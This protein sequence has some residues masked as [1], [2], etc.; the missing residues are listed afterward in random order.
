MKRFS[1]P[2]KTIDLSDPVNNCLNVYTLAASAAGV[3][4]LS[5][6]QPAEQAANCNHILS[7]PH[8]PQPRF[9]QV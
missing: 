3:G 1:G 9:R 2:R 8:P 5:L 6:S 7:L 4:I